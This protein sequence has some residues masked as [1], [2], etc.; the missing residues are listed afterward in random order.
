MATV[1]PC[2]G[3]GVPWSCAITGLEMDKARKLCL[4]GLVVL[5]AAAIGGGCTKKDAAPAD[6]APCTVA[7]ADSVGI[8]E[9]DTYLCKSE[10]CFVRSQ[11]TA[12][13]AKALVKAE[14]DSFR[15]VSRTPEGKNGSLKAMCVT[16]LQQL[17]VNPGCAAK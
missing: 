5:A 8:V 9:C 17:A 15:I 4:G 14:R 10:A 1:P 2:E 12:A 13:M 6:D 3:S 16:K 7:S 11:R